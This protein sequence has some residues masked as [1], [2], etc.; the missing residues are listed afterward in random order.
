MIIG[1]NAS[2]LR[3][4]DSGTGQVT[5]NFIRTL[6]E[7]IEKQKAVLSPDVKYILYLEENIDLDLPDN[8]EKQVFLPAYKRDDLIR[9][10]IWEKFLLPKQVRDD[11]C[12][13]FFSLYQ[14]ATILKGIK[15]IMLVH[16]TVWKIFPQYVN[17]LRKKIYYSFVD[18]AINKADHVLTVSHNSK[19][20]IKKYYDVADKIITVNYIDCDQVYKNPVHNEEI[21]QVRRKYHLEKDY[22]FYIGGFDTRKNVDRI[23][24][25]YGLLLKDLPDAPDLVLAGMF[26]PQLVPLITDIPK[27]IQEVSHVSGVSI[28][29]IKN[30]GFVPQEDVPALYH[31]AKLFCYPSLYEGFGL[32]VVEA[33]NCDCPV[34]TSNTS[35]LKEIADA[36]CAFVVDPGDTE[37][38]SNAMK[39]GLIDEAAR[40]QIA[41]GGRERAQ[42]FSWD[43]FTESVIELF[44]TI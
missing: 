22:I 44:K 40:E 43:S 19:E 4:P 21:E 15:H 30:I 24:D 10:F 28:S 29:K 1:I 20:D 25:A 36:G 2:F 39:Q 32:P 26:H 23:I 42:Q 11:G 27:K 37:A 14:S 9:K 12:D 6:A 41:A 33:Y 35:S 13:L 34:I 7:K 16:D 31:G 38:I 5:A 17:N 18:R 3:K 8:M